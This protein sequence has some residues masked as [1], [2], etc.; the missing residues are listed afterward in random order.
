MRAGFLLL[1]VSLVADGAY[2]V[3]AAIGPASA[4][5]SGT[6]ATAVHVV[7][8]AGMAVTFAG[9]LQVAF[10]PQGAVRGKETQ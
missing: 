3:I 9:V 1:A 7:V 4:S 8:L 2:H 5:H 6:V 10:R